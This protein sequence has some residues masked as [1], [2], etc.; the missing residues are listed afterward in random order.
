MIG[1]CL[2][3]D[4][5]RRRE[6]FILWLDCR[7]QSCSV[8]LNSRSL[9]FTVKLQQNLSPQRTQRFTEKSFDCTGMVL[10]YGHPTLVS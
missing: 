8:F 7:Y 5:E 6:D 1:D 2:A 3:E 9:G 4:I 10:R